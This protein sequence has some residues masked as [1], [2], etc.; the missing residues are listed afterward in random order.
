MNR[1][2]DPVLDAPR[3]A[4]SPRTAYV[5][6]VLLA[7]TLSKDSGVALIVAADP[8]SSG[9]TSVEW[10]RFKVQLQRDEN[11]R[12]D[13]MTPEVCG[14]VLM[15]FV[16]SRY[17]FARDMMRATRADY[18]TENLFADGSHPSYTE[19]RGFLVGECDAEYFAACRAAFAQVAMNNR[20]MS[21]SWRSVMTAW[22]GSRDTGEG[23]WL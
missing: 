9:Q 18:L 17:L 22:Q 19:M 1:T 10:Q 4:A 11:A 6:V 8:R 2:L 3:R 20:L 12:R 16:E 5:A 7:W 14:L 15:A 13:R 23:G 21:Q